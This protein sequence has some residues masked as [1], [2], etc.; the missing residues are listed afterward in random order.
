MMTNRLLKITIWAATSVTLLSV[1]FAAE[2]PAALVEDIHGKVRGVEFMDY[3]TAG[4]AIKLGPKDT[5]VLGYMKSCW[6]ETITGGVVTVGEE[7][8]TVSDGRI[9]RSKVA[10]DIGQMQVSAHAPQSAGITFRGAPESTP[11]PQLTIYGLSPV[12]Q[13]RDGGLLV[14][15]R[16][17]KP[18]DRYEVRIGANAPVRG[19]F[20][21]FAKSGKSLSADAIYVARLGGQEIVFKVD[22]L[23]KPGSTPVI[24]RLVS[25]Q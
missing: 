2:R 3:V 21:D 24:G 5:I 23:A 15:E 8:S 4:Q 19:R 18:G 13:G 25:F 7:Q 9:E 17:D 11:R 6:R 12:V 14:I 10:C 22:P 16:L 20:Y 1:A